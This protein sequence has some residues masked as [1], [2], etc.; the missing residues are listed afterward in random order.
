MFD[1]ERERTGIEQ[2][3]QLRQCQRFRVRVRVRVRL[4]RLKSVWILHGSAK[5]W[6][7]IRGLGLGSGLGSAKNWVGIRG[8]VEPRRDLDVESRGRVRVCVGIAP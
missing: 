6:V 5:N 4:Q 3:R 8:R 7:G 2:L 1:R